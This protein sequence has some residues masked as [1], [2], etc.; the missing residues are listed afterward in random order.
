M[1]SEMVT[2][3]SAQIHNESQRRRFLACCTSL[4]EFKKN[5]RPTKYDEQTH[6]LLVLYFSA[7]GYSTSQIACELGV[8]RTSIYNWI[9]TH[10]TFC[11]AYKKGR[12]LS[13][14]FYEE[15][16]NGFAGSSQTSM[17]Q[18]LQVQS[19]IRKRFN[20]LDTDHME[21]PGF[22]DAKDDGERVEII[23]AA[24]TSGN[25]SVGAGLNI[26][27]AMKQAHEIELLPELQMQLDLLKEKLK[28]T[29]D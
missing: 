20:G 12:N 28:Q 4:E 27:N 3:L 5:G 9:G 10:P 8:C 15:L 1:S 14:S 16:E 24:M 7:L 19:I 2:E 6:P 29:G 21:I 22:S 18:F 11:T 26:I 17:V 23:L 13:L 25:M